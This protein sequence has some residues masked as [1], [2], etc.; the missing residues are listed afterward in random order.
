VADQ[1]PRRIKTLVYMDA[2]VPEAGSTLFSLRPE[3]R[4][5]F[6]EQAAAGAGV[7]VA[8]RPASAFDTALPEDWAWMDSKTTPHP[9][10]CFAQAL[11]LTGRHTEVRK[12]IY[13]YAEGGICD[14]MYDGY[15]SNPDSKV[16]AVQDS[17]HSIMID[18]PV[19]VAEILIDA[20]AV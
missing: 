11:R 4:H 9:F 14:G 16:I 20:G 6:L 1:V 3:Y 8:P 12:R 17:G 19:K 5:P 13:I 2:L 7:L 18:Q 10:A 15:R